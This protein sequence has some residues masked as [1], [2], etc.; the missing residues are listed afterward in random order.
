[1]STPW[2]PTAPGVLRLPSGLLVRGRGLRHPLPPGPA[3]EFALHL[4][5]RR[6]APTE[7]ES[8]WLRWPD[9]W[10]P[11]DRAGFAAALRAL[12]VRAAE[13]RVE[14]A[15][16]GGLG[17]TGTALAC[18]AVLDGVPNSE[19]VAYVREHY[20]RRAV[21]TPWQRRFVAQFS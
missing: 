2:E 15:C 6:P 3:P 21:E 8:Q 14:V 17:R 12:L 11:S 18:L 19:A 7:G 16:G 20:A 5:G 1:M 4:R 9:F 13:Q 10:L